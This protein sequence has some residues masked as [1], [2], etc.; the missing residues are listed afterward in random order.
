MWSSYFLREFQKCGV[1]VFLGVDGPWADKNEIEKNI[2]LQYF[3]EYILDEIYQP[4]QKYDLAISL[5]VAEHVAEAYADNFVQTLV[6]A[7]EQI[8]FSAAA[9]IT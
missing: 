1:P 6:N 5:E 4:K 7:S 2:G 9:P 8:L 3:E